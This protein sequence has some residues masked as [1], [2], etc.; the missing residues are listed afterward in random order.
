MNDV[1]LR[2]LP[3]VLEITEFSCNPTNFSNFCQVAPCW[4][5][6]GCA[7]RMRYRWRLRGTFTDATDAAEQ[8]A[9]RALGQP[10]KPETDLAK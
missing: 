4:T 10:S 5:A 2:L 7:G 3:D 6:R 9:A 8:I 1:G